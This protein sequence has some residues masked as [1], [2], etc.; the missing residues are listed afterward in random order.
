MEDISQWPLEK[1]ETYLKKV[2]E[3]KMGKTLNLENP[4][5]FSEMIQWIKLYYCNPQISRCVDKVLF[6]DFIK[7]RLGEGYTAKTY[8]VWEK[9][10]EVNLRDIPEQCVVKSN[11]SSDG[12]NILLVPDKSKIDFEKVEREIK[13]NWFDR[14]KLHTNSFASYYYGVQ[15]KV[16]V[17]EY[18]KEAEDSP[19][20]Y[21]VFCFHGE[22]KFIYVKT[23]HFDNGINRDVYPVSFYTTEWNFME[24]KYKDFPS[25]A[26]LERPPHLDEML[27]ISRML[28]KGFPFV[29]VDFFEN[30]RKLHVAEFSFAPWA[31]LRVYE[32]EA[33]DYEM[34][35]WLDIVHTAE[36]E[37]VK[38]VREGYSE[39]F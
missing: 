9:A 39:L 10:E 30:S 13:G 8:K 16:Y 28:S 18:L 33:L 20:D 35:K 23:A 26:D 19:D 37:Y 25:R 36:A 1:R 22:P 15:P 6:K 7:E 31:G 11:C 17:E 27:E 32:P 38:K 21:D 5:S 12:R 34:G 24:A 3:E 14:L 2:F 29:R 4:K